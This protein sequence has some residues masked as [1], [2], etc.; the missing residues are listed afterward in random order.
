[1]EEKK[2]TINIYFIK[3]DYTISIKY[4]LTVNLFSFFNRKNHHIVF[5]DKYLDGD[6]ITKEVSN[7][8]YEMLYSQDKILAYAIL[9]NELCGLKEKNG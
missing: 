7:T 5:K 6:V 2:H 4:H 3:N 8:L 1:M 9:E